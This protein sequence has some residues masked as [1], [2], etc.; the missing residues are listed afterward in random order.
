MAGVVYVQSDPIGLAGGINTYS[1]VAGNPL[2]FVDP[3]GLDHI[4][5]TYGQSSNFGT[6]TYFGEGFTST[7]EGSTGRIG[8]TDPSVPWAGPLPPGVYTLDPSQITDGGFWRNLTGD[9]GDFRVPLVPD[10]GTNTFGRNRFFIHG[11]KKPGSAGCFDVGQ[12]DRQ[13]F[14]QLRTNATGPIKV[15]VSNCECQ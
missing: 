13:L 12:S 7:Y 6:L 11:G 5:I 8:N 14:P 1:Y 4:V 3:R 9:W 15:Y 10:R 2:R